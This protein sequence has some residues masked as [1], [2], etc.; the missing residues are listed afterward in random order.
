MQVFLPNQSFL[1]SF[2]SGPLGY[3]STQGLH[4]DCQV[5]G[6]GD[7]GEAHGLMKGQV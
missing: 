7:R 1:W 2:L 3:R 6:F 5:H 4:G